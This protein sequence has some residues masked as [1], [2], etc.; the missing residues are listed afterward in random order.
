M[1]IVGAIL[2]ALIVLIQYPLWLGKG[3]VAV[4]KSPR[5]AEMLRA[6]GRLVPVPA[7]LLARPQPDRDGL[8]QA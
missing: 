2:A 4:H 3:D 7:A 6:K 8:L 5:A 1:K